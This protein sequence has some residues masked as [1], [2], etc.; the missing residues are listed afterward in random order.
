MFNENQIYMYCEALYYFSRLLIILMLFIKQFYQ[1]SFYHSRYFF[2]KA[3]SDCW[4]VRIQLDLFAVR[5]NTVQYSHNSSKPRNFLERETSGACSY[6]DPISIIGGV[7]GE[8]GSSGVRSRRYVPAY[9][10]REFRV[11]RTYTNATHVRVETGLHRLASAHIGI[12][13]SLT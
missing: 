6:Y 1:K 4:F 7:V 10:T 12:T 13:L 5:C 8:E 3:Q 11:P 2:F 9:V